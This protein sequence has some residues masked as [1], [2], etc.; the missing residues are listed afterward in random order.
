MMFHK[1]I[2]KV[3]F[4]KKKKEKWQ[5]LGSI[6]GLD[7]ACKILSLS[8]KQEK[9]KRKNEKWRKDGRTYCNYCSCL[10]A[11]LKNCDVPCHKFLNTL[12]VVRVSQKHF[13]RHA[14]PNLDPKFSAFWNLN[15]RNISIFYNFFQEPSQIQY[16]PMSQRH[17][18]MFE[19]HI[20]EI[21]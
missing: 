21:N 5:H 3:K 14:V 19:I 11:I 6:F 4:S 8:V 9:S 17:S 20:K 18:C 7:Q 15:S 13:K 1:F 12:Q 16:F 10:R 2:G